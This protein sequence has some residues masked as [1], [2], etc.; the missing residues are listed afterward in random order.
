MAIK[1]SYKGVDKS[2]P[3][4]AR[5]IKQ[6][7]QKSSKLISGTE[8]ICVHFGKSGKQYMA[9]LNINPKGKFPINKTAE[10]SDIYTLVDDLARK[11][12]AQAKQNKKGYRSTNNHKAE[13]LKVRD[14][15]NNIDDIDEYDE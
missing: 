14:S 9:T 8:D 5:C 11:A 15:V 3:L 7:T 13:I 4:E 2:Q 6:L 1:F 12:V 10:G